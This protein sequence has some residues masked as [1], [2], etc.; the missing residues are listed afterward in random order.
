VRSRNESECRTA[1]SSSTTWTTGLDG[2][3]D[4]LVGHGLQGEA[5]NRTAARV[6]VGSDLPAM[7]L[8]DGARD[9]QTHPHAVALGRDEGLEQLRCDLGRDAGAGIGHAD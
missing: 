3:A 7:R 9:R 6:A 1:S 2:M 5:E 8:D 4:L